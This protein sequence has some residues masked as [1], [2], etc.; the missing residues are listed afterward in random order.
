VFLTSFKL[1]FILIS[2][3]T[4]FGQVKLS[5]IGAWLGRRNKNPRAFVGAISRG[6]V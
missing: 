3:D 6:N 2:G 1:P 4:P 5:E